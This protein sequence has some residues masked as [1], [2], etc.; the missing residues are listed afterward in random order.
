MVMIGIFLILRIL[1]NNQNQNFSFYRTLEFYA[2][3]KLFFLWPVAVERCKLYTTH[4]AMKGNFKKRPLA[5]GAS[6][7]ERKTALINC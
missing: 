3:N 2:K 1:G 4:R 5:E 7:N 6:E